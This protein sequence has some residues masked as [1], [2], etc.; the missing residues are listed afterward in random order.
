MTTTAVLYSADAPDQAIELGSQ[1]LSGLTERQ[2]LWIDLASPSPGE[3]DAVARLVGCRP[4]ELALAEEDSRPGLVNYGDRFHVCAKA[5]SLTRSTDKLVRE[6]LSLV[7]GRN[8]VVTVHLADTDFLEQLRQREKGDSTIGALSAE[9]FA[10]SLLDRLLDTYF[11]ALDVIVR[12]IDRVEI[13]ILGR[14]LPPQNL[15][16][17]VA[18]RRRI[19]DLRRLL[20]AHR[21]VFY[22][23]ARPDFVATEHP[24]ARLHFDALNKHYERAEDDL[25]TARDLVV[26][27]FE[28]LSTRAAQKTNDTMR[29]LTFVTV[30][31][32]VLALVA[33][34][35]GMNF[36]LP[37]FDTGMRGFVAVLVSMAAFAGVGLALAKRR[38]WI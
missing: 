30:M 31:M 8:Y 3:I 29:V 23:M 35:L 22:G 38:G 25:E 10:A 28:L 18:A 16:L 11:N 33:G 37:L 27:S 12:D 15:E 2:L 36:A 13:L 7:V 20:K 4:S 24:E 34:L 19:A 17:L 32:G 21:D 5:V 9:S 1:T 6:S 26:G 14:Q